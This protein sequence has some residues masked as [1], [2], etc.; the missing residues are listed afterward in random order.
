MESMKK[1]VQTPKQAI[2]PPKLTKRKLMEGIAAS[3]LIGKKQYH[4]VSLSTVD[5]SSQEAAHVSFVEALLSQVNMTKTQLEEVRLQDVRLNACILVMANWYKAAV[6]RAEFIGC[7]MTGFGA[8]E[9]LFQDVVFQEC[10]MNLAQLRFA[11]FR[12]VR[13]ERCDLSEADLVGADLSHVVLTHCS[14]RHADLSASKLDGVDL[15]T[16]NLDGARVGLS[17]LRGA[18]IDVKQA[19]SLVEAL[20]IEVKLQKVDSRSD[21]QTDG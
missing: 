12:S 2:V 7:R 15:S 5:L 11:T 14:L 19:L 21:S 20:G 9:A 13:F 18:T 6:Y 10:Q 17:E 4:E 8:G 3:C 16:C 1:T